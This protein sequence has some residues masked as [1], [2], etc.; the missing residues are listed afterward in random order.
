MSK[1][2]H[3]ISFKVSSNDVAL[4]DAIVKRAM[5]LVKKYVVD[6]LSLTMDITAIHANG[7][8]LMLADLLQSNDFG[9]SHDIYGILRHINRDTGQLE[10]CFRPRFAAREE[11][12]KN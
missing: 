8:P 5:P 7:C 3:E 4:I 11:T 2:T 12:G 1:L 10:D 9:F 6:S